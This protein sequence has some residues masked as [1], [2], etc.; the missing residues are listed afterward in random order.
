MDPPI[1]GYELETRNDLEFGSL[2]N[3]WPTPQTNWVH[4]KSRCILKI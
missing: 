4:M 3:K 1:R 2:C